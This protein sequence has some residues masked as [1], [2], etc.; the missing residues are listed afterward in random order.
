[1]GLPATRPLT[2]TTRH[3]RI[4]IIVLGPAHGHSALLWLRG[5]PT[6]GLRKEASNMPDVPNTCSLAV[7]T[8]FGSTVACVRKCRNSSS[9]EAQE[10]QAFPTWIIWGAKRASLLL[11]AL[12]IADAV[13]LSTPRCDT[14]RRSGVVS[15]R[16]MP[17]RFTLVRR[18]WP[19]LVENRWQRTP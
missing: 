4:H 5:F 14:S 13:G 16:C 8:C 11:G 2:Q 12:R 6:G 10:I 15:H 7:D 3:L 18:C 17:C 9:N 19:T 1:M